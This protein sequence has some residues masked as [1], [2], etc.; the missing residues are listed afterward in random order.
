MK[1]RRNY[2]RILQVQPDASQAV[3]HASYKAIMRVL[4]VHP[5]LGGTHWNAT[6]VNEAFSVLRDHPRRVAYD[7]ELFERYTK[8]IWDVD[9]LPIISYF[10]PFCKRP[11]ARQATANETCPSCRSPLASPHTAN[12]H[13]EQR[14]VARLSKAGRIQLYTP[15]SPTPEVG[16]L[17]DLTPQGLRFQCRA[18]L[19]PTMTIKI[20]SR[21]FNAVAV[22]RHSQKIID[23]STISYA[24]GVAFLTVQFTQPKGGFHSSSA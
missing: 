19:L 8:K 5:D 14:A 6:I 11:F 1:N 21:E 17:L 2:Y 10:C 22:V 15:W 23:H 18:K 13:Q 4:K 20:S 16:D 24:T 7:R 3:I 12:H 9:R